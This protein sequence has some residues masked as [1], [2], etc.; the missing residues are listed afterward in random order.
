[1]RDFNM[2]ITK[3]RKATFHQVGKLFSVDFSLAWVFNLTVIDVVTHLLSQ[4]Q[5]DVYLSISKAD[6]FMPFQL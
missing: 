2:W 6:F 1:M 5:S 4:Y 3:K